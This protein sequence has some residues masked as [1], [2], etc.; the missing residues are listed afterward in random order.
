[1]I[2]VLD[3]NVLIAL[4]RIIALPHHVFWT[5]DIAL[6]SSEHVEPGRLLWG[7]DKSPMPICW[8]WL[9]GTAGASPPSTAG[10]G[11]WCPAAFRR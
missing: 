7:I 9:C 2:G 4:R 8:L 6:S 11:S 3:I 1:M 10:S 5:D